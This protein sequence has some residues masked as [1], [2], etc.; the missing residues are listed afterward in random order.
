[1]ATYR[2]GLNYQ[3]EITTDEITVIFNGTTYTVPKRTRTLPNSDTYVYYGTLGLV[4]D[5]DATGD[6]PFCIYEANDLNTVYVSTDVYNNHNPFTIKIMEESVTTTE[7]FKKAV[8]SIASGGDCDCGY[9]CTETVTTLT[10]ETVTTTASEGAPR[11]MGE[12]S[13]AQLI[14][15]D[16]LTVTF[17]G[18]EYECPLKNM[19]GYNAYGGFSE[20][21][22]FDFSEY[23]FV[24]ASQGGE[25]GNAC[26]T[27]SAGTYAIK[28][29][30][31]RTMISTTPCFEKAVGKLTESI[32]PLIVPLDNSIALATSNAPANTA[33]TAEVISDAFLSG[34]TVLFVE[35]TNPT[36]AHV[37]VSLEDNSKAVLQT[38]DGSVAFSVSGGYF[39]YPTIK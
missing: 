30:T 28:I 1:M 22:G 38:E 7:C 21:T 34:R 26:F 14:D 3:N 27:A 18:V 6:Y 12:L 25:A 29:E 32:S 13:Y 9:E 35:P 37:V 15:A 36:A 23:P 31:H 16:N 5:G 4:D 11:A 8:R 17:D 39:T 20:T 24:I 19:G 2:A 10:E 33:L